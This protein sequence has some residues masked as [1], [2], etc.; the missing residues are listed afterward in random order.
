V[1]DVH[2]ALKIGLIGYRNQAERLID[3]IKSRADSKL[4]CIYHPTKKFDDSLF[5]NRFDDLLVCDAIIISSPNDTHYKYLTKLQNFDGY[6]FCEKP[7]VTS[8]NDLEKL[9]KNDDGPR[10]NLC[11][12]I[13]ENLSGAGINIT[14]YVKKADVFSMIF[15]E[16]R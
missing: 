9:R 1:I 11:P 13:L 7:P 14:V 15:Y 5:T 16:F 12:K 4:E 2:L 3:I 6:I 10:D 8:I